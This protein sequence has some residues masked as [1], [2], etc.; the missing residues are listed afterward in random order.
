MQTRFTPDQLADPEVAAAESILRSCVHC[1]FCTATCPT[2]V[3]LGD[4]LD[5]PRGR[6]YLIKE[7]LERG[8][9]AT[10]TV[11]TH[12]D[13][14]LSCLACVT[15]C[16]SSVDYMHLVDHARAHI[17][18]TFRR[19][20]AERALRALLARVLPAPNLFRLA[21]LGARL[22]RPI[23]P[24]LPRRL[25]ALLAL[26]PAR[27]AAPPARP[28][29]ATYRPRGAPALR[30][31]LLRGCVQD[32]LDPDINAATI[33]LLTRLGCEVVVAPGSGCCGALTHHL[34]K[35]RPARASARANIAAWT[36]EIEGGGL[37]AIVVN[38]SGCG[39]MVKDYGHL[40]RNDAEWAARAA[41]V[42]ARTRD[43]A[44]LL[45]DLDVAAA[46]RLDA[47]PAAIKVAYHAACSLQ[48]GQGV[49][50]QP[51]A[52][53]RRTGFEVVEIGEGHLCC[54]SAGSYNLLQPELA[55]RLRE[56]KAAH[57]AA[58]G[59][60]VVAAGNI[61]CITQLAGATA[62]PVLHLVQLLDWATGGPRPAALPL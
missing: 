6:I 44:E 47:S 11:A 28:P 54:G 52:L 43:V 7:M 34:G 18:A 27:I 25:G 23:A 17:E 58:S 1:G 55:R 29:G 35:G 38:A 42:S 9:A 20:P 5:S 8:K 15:T 21:L 36:R 10:A 32:V 19:P 26:A 37:D 49:T 46:R 22:A 51:P 45:A 3:L 50:D 24:W 13:R 57:I 4:E 14:C 31:A 12:I 16:P 56:R 39:T 2:Y 62:V 48:H 30:V 60:T 53:L 40:L 59:G 61:G 33:R 41:A